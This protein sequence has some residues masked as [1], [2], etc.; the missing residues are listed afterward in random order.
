M[1]KKILVSGIQPTG[2]LHLG[3]YLGA[4]QNWVHLQEDYDAYFMIADLHALTTTYENPKA[5]TQAKY[6]LALD[7]LAAGV[8]PE[9]SCLF[10]QSDVY[11]HCELHLLLSMITPL[12]W[13][14]RIPSY[15]DKMEEIKGK[16][17]NTYGFLGYPLLQ[18]ADILLYDA[19]VVPVGKD[20]LPHLELTREIARRMNHF[21]KTKLKEPK[22]LLTKYPIVLGIDG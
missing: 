4:I 19:D 7:L 16:D 5:L 8:D 3:N 11:Q 22:E 14:T 13:L 9:K 10:Y 18:A 12:P 17:L 21:Y 6:D 15:K 1:T 2:Q 20:Q